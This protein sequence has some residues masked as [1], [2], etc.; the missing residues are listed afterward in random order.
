[1]KQKNHFDTLQ[2]HAGQETTLGTNARAVPIFSSSSFTFDS[3][4]HASNLFSLKEFGNI[5][6]RIMNPTT[7]VFEKRV[8]ALGGR[9]RCISN[10]KWT[11]SAIFSNPNPS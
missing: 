3:A 11:S 9:S 6:T 4:E 8:A 2:V 1:M 10:I 7:D 5:Y